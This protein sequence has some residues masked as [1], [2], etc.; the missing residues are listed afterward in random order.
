MMPEK[1]NSPDRPGPVP[2]MP[3]RVQMLKNMAVGLAPLIIFVIVDA[4]AQNAYDETTS[5][6]LALGAALILGTAQFIYFWARDGKPEP[7]ILADTGLLLVMGLISLILQKDIFFKLKPAIIEAILLIIIGLTA[8]STSDML[9]KMTS[10]YM[11]EVRF[12]QAQIESMRRMMRTFFFCLLIHTALIVYAAFYLSREMWAFISGGLFYIFMGVALLYEFIKARISQ[13]AMKRKYKSEE[14]L[15]IVDSQGKTVGSAPRSVCHQNPN[16][17]HQAV[18]LHVIDSQGRIYLQKRSPNK[19]VQPRKWDTAVGGHVVRGE[20]IENALTR[21]IR[22]ELGMQRLPHEPLFRYL[23]RTD[24]ESELVIAFRGFSNGPFTHP[25][26]EIE[27]GKF[28]SVDEIDA[29]LDTGIF[30]P[31]FEHEYRVMKSN[32][33]VATN[34]TMNNDE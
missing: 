21:E 9:L 6:K 28:W 3:S 5:L 33:I 1:Y 2:G 17:I 14:W 18:H 26:A 7:F 22:E 15:D 24:I 29:N 8:F 30:T 25:E 11:K 19:T 16:L 23:W 27:E 20:S 12:N 13:G 4:W 10:R 34:D 32:G 31:N